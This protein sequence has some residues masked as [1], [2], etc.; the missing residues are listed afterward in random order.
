VDYYR[1]K[2]KKKKYNSCSLTPVHVCHMLRI[3]SLLVLL[4]LSVIDL[5]YMFV[6]VLI[7]F[8]INS[9]KK[10]EKKNQIVWSC[11]PLLQL[12]QFVQKTVAKKVA[13]VRITT[14]MQNE[15]FHSGS[16]VSSCLMGLRSTRVGWIPS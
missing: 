10:I 1:K 5:A 11:H 4:T 6:P 14:L 2:K 13:D 15:K 9:G 8:I 7:C 16:Y 12:N 3:F